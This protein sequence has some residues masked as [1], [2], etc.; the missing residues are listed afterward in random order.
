MTTEQIHN[1]LKSDP[2]YCYAVETLDMVNMG[3]ILRAHGLGYTV[4]DI[5]KIFEYC[6]VLA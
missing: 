2:A 3:I 5:C 1:M 4:E 6:G